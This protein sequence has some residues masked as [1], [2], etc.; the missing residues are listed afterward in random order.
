[1]RRVSPIHTMMNTNCEP[2]NSV[3]AGPCYAVDWCKTAA[4]SQAQR[5][6]SAFRLALGSF[7]EDF[8]NRIAI[9]G[10][11][12]ERVLVE[13]DYT[14]FPDFATLV[15][16]HHGYPATSIQW[17]P[18]MAAKHYNQAGAA[19][20][21]ELLATSGDALRVWE[22]GS[23]VQPVVGNYVGMKATGPGYR[24]T[25]KSTLSGVSKDAL[26]FIRK[27]IADLL[28]SQKSNNRETLV[29]RSQTSRGTKKRPL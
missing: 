26:C 15:E 3:L 19:A 20:A 24:L 17:Q 14:D 2:A 22:Y 1:M 7:T 13:D 6:R 27:L 5:P 29:H 28:C 23:D 9:V 12:D 25:M 10:L 21:T 8:R 11:Q 16:T 18:A 4:P